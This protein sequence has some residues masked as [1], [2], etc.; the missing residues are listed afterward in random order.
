MITGEPPRLSARRSSVQA[1]ERVTATSHATTR[2]TP[3]RGSYS[4]FAGIFAGEIG[5]AYP[6]T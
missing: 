2:N 3:E 5:I 1:S 4:C 6:H